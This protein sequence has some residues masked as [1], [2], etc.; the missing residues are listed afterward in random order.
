MPFRFLDKDEYV[1]AYELVR[2]TRWLG[3]ETDEESLEGVFTVVCTDE[4]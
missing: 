4:I 2:C 3:R 1:Y